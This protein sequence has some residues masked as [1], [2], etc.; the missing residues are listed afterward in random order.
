MTNKRCPGRTSSCEGQQRRQIPELEPTAANVSQLFV[1]SAVKLSSTNSTQSLRFLVGLD[2]FQWKFFLFLFKNH[3]LDL[4]WRNGIKRRLHGS[5]AAAADES[6]RSPHECRS[7]RGHED[8]RHAAASRRVPPQHE[9]RAPVPT[10]WLFSFK[11]PLY[12]IEKLHY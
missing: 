10:G 7:R 3:L 2:Y 1:D 9:Q 4:C 12:L 11:N 6:E 8:G 5:S